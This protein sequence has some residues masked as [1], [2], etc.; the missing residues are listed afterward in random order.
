MIRGGTVVEFL[1]TLKTPRALGVT[2]APE[3]LAGA[4]RRIE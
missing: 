3:L 2:L 4:D 1:V